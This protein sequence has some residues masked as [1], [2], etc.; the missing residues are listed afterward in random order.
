MSERTTRRI[1]ITASAATLLAAAVTSVLLV[2]DGASGRDPVS[3]V[4]MLGAVGCY[5]VVGGLIASRLPRNACGWLLLLIGSGLALTMCAEAVSDIAL[6]D[7][8]ATLAAWALWLNSWLLVPTAWSGILLY[9]LVFPTGRP[10]SRRWRPVAIVVIALSVMGVLVRMVQPWDEPGLTHPLSLPNVAPFAG[11]VFTAIA[12]AFAATG[13]LV[14]VAVAMRFRHASQQERLALRWLAVV[15]VLA[16]VLMVTA[17]GAGALGLHR[18]GDPLGALFLLVVIVGLP[19]SAAVALLTHRISGIEVV[20]NRSVVYASIVA[21]ITVIYAVIVAGVGA[22][23]GRSERSDVLAAVAATAVAAVAF[24][25]ARRRAQRFADRLIYGDRS[26]PYELVATFTERLDDASLPDVL[27]RMT[28]LIAEGT[29]AD[30]VWIWLRTGAELWAVAAWPA[31]AAPPTPAHLDDGE[32][33]HLGDPAFAVRHA[34]ELLGAITVGMPPQEPMTPA[35]ERLLTDLSAQAGLVLRNVALVQELQRSR[36][37]LVTSEAAARRRLERD[38]HDGA[39]QRLVTLS[40]DLRLARDRA[41]ATGDADLTARLGEAEQELAGSLAELRELARGIHPAILTQNGV[42]AAVRSLAD[43]SAVPVELG[44][45][46]NGRFP[47]EVEATAYFVV[48][49]ALANVAK[50]AHASHVWIAVE[51]AGGRL[52]IDVRDD[53]EGGATLEGGSGLRGLAD[54]VEA[55]GGRIDVRSEPGAGSTVHA[56]IPCASR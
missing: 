7:G 16:A 28:A 29:G 24:Q 17:I 3:D 43:R 8:R 9:V 37:R 42:G 41:D 51:D 4:V 32:L 46:P 53:G 6:R 22:V 38:L 19:A 47:P 18:V 52:T 12:L 45:L 50:H 10:P 2:L 20:A 54:R 11:S 30:R 21:T 14:V 40:M 31:G 15:A 55:V 34:G 13:V 49:E 23:V 33:P 27:P 56:E 39:Q 25:P 5:A 26:S 1:A 35:T 48:S 44:P 36:Q